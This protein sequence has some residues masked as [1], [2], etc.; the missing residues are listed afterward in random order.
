MSPAY[1]AHLPPAP[2]FSYLSTFQ[3]AVQERCLLR[4]TD[5]P[6]RYDPDGLI[7]ASLVCIPGSTQLLDYS[8]NLLGTFQIADGAWRA[9]HATWRPGQPVQ[10]PANAACR[11]PYHWYAV[12]I[13]RLHGAQIPCAE[14]G[15]GGESIRC[16]VC[17]DP[18]HANYWH[19]AVRFADQ[20]GMSLQ[21]LKAGG[22]LTGGGIKRIIG[23]LRAWMRECIGSPAQLV[24][25]KSGP[26]ASGIV[27]LSCCQHILPD[28]CP[29]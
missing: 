20:N 13:S 21:V 16:F 4:A 25:I 6:V 28:S 27:P 22:L 10:P 8:I 23:N 15:V 3:Q 14:A 12:P 19:F 24:A 5:Q 9:D 29:A 26:S 1:P 7:E 11:V 2:G 18:T 17:H